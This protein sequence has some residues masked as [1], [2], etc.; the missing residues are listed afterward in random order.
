[1]KQRSFLFIILIFFSAHSFSWK[2]G[3]TEV[4]PLECNELLKNG[5][6][7]LIMKITADSGSYGVPYLV[8]I[9]GE[10]EVWSKRFTASAV[11]LAKFDYSCKGNVITLWSAYPGPNNPTSQKIT[12]NGKNLEKQIEFLKSSNSG[13]FYESLPEEVTDHYSFWAKKGQHIFLQVNNIYSPTTLSFYGRSSAE[14]IEKFE[15]YKDDKHWDYILP[16]TGKYKISVTNIKGEQKY[17]T[18][19][20]YLK[21]KIQ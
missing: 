8:G 6:D 10:K 19:M 17:D 13:D 18:S 3:K 2:E 11:N 15:F 12:W 16:E 5:A 14:P 1:M 7:R 9:K 4:F 20:Y 21:I